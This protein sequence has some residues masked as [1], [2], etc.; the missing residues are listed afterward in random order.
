[1]E[2]CRFTIGVREYHR[3]KYVYDA[4][5]IR[6]GSCKGHGPSPRQGVPPFGRRR[7]GSMNFGHRRNTSKVFRNFKVNEPDA[8]TIRCELHVIESISNTIRYL[9]YGGVEL[10]VV[11][12]H[13]S[14]EIVK[15]TD[16][17]LSMGYRR[18]IT[19]RSFLC[20]SRLFVYPSAKKKVAENDCS[21]VTA[22]CRRLQKGRIR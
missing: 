12:Y 4:Y 13:K 9:G 1:M 20:I 21:P 15:K 6:V 10:V 22:S 14:Q 3:G 16:T 19:T 2:D 8:R 18:Q 11:R 5:S 7:N 17:Y